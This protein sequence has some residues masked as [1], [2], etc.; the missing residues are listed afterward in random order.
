MSAFDH[1]WD[2]LAGQLAAAAQQLGLTI[3]EVQKDKLLK[4]LMLLENWNRVHSLSAWK[5]PSDLLV[6][7]VVDS[8]TLLGPLR[9][10][11]AGA[12]LRVLDA[13]SGPGFPASVLAVMEPEWLVT[14]VDAVAKKVAFIRQAAAEVGISNLVASHSRLEKLVVGDLFDV[15]VSR[16]LGSLKD[17]TAKTRHLLLPSG[18]WVAQKGRRPDREAAEL[19]RDLRVFHV[20]P[21]TVP[22]LPVER[23]LVWIRREASQ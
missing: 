13:G 15:V 16:A 11:A 9:R 23:C 7:H 6:R 4:Y 2:A 1:A 17:M 3:D 19:P 8:L 10:H 18:V 21:V 22:D 12:R 5:N 14:A 20:E